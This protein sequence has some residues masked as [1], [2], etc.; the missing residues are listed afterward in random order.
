M[1]SVEALAAQITVLQAPHPAMAKRVR[2]QRVIPKE[3]I[4]SAI[5]AVEALPVLESVNKFNPA[6]AREVLQFEEAFIPVVRRIE[7]LAAN[8]RYTL[9]A[10]RA[11]V[12]D[13]A[14]QI[15]AIAKGVARDPDSADVAGHVALMKRDLGRRGRRGGSGTDAR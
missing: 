10:R 3:F 11:D 4:W 6:N 2:R 15:Y 13:A 9:E 7:M 14:L 1:D 5:A 8:L 12:T